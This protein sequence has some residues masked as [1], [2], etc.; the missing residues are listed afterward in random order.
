MF[1]MVFTNSAILASSDAFPMKGRILRIGRGTKSTAL[2]GSCFSHQDIYYT[3][4]LIMCKFLKHQQDPDHCSDYKWSSISL[5]K[6]CEWL[7]WPEWSEAGTAISDCPSQQKTMH[8][9]L[10]FVEC[11]L[12]SEQRLDRQSL[13]NRIGYRKAIEIPSEYVPHCM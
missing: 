6:C 10:R 8:F 13:Q 3:F 2:G 7:S 9:R 4:G 11:H 12:R 1:Q 5:S